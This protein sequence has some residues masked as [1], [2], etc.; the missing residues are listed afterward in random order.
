MSK[1]V[2]SLIKAK[3][4]S[5][6]SNDKVERKRKQVKN[7]LF[8]Q[9]IKRWE[10][11]TATQGTWQSCLKT[12]RTDV[13]IKTICSKKK[14]S[15]SVFERNLNKQHKLS[16][17]NLHQSSIQISRSS[18]K[19]FFNWVLLYKWNLWNLLLAD[20]LP[21]RQH[22]NTTPMNNITKTLPE[23]AFYRLF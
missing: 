18:V 8:V 15:S 20:R 19:S 3:W 12:R 16:F 11:S 9:W 23:V 14:F 7:Y 22:T 10:T 13:R 1:I 21:S 4:L 6:E 2:L 5:R 17:N